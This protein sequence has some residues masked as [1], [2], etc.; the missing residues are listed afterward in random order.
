MDIKEEE[1]LGAAVNTHWYYQSKLA[2][3][4]RALRRIQPIHILDV[5]AG[6]G[7]FSK[8]LLH[9]PGTESALCV[10]VNYTS[11]RTEFVAGKPMRFRRS[12]ER[13]DADLVLLM[14]VLEHVADDRAL[15]REYISKTPPQTQFFISVPAFQWLWSDHDIYLGHQRRYTLRNATQMIEST[16]LRVISASYFFGLV[17]PLAACMRIPQKFLPKARRNPNSQLRRHSPI[18]NRTLRS[19]CNFELPWYSHNRV[20][21]LS[22]FLLANKP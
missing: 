14:D 9:N 17:L 13:A 3:L 18:V 5:G 6:S 16:G 7:F 1:L 2:A 20:G 8:A 11:E 21:G 19:L 10:D 12:V 15:V 22:V 4:R